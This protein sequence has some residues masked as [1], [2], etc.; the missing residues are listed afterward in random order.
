M[1]ITEAAV[2]RIKN[3]AAAAVVNE[4]VTRQRVEQVEQRVEV[5]VRVLA[6]PFLGR[7]RWLFLGR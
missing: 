4:H 6:R 5:V 2:R 7:L 3:D 1:R